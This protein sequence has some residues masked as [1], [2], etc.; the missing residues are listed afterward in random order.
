MRNLHPG[1]PDHETWGHRALDTLTSMALVSPHA[2]ASLDEREDEL[3]H[4][5][6]NEQTGRSHTWIQHHHGSKKEVSH[7]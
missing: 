7:A 5:R 3:S 4:L 6:P 2:V 1:R